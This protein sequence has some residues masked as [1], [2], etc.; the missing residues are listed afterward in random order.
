LFLA[1][2]G[3]SVPELR[4]LLRYPLQQLRSWFVVRVLQHELAADGKIEKSLTELL[5]QIGACGEGGQHVECEAG[6]VLKGFGIER[7]DPRILIRR[8][9]ES[10][11]GAR[12]SVAINV[13]C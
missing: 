2:N 11:Q 3:A 6:V 1:R 10:W 8:S 4:P 7:V 12:K 9:D 13:D 5:D